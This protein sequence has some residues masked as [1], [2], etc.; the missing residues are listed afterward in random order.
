M[1]GWVDNMLD[2]QYWMHFERLE[3]VQTILSEQV[4]ML[5]PQD[6]YLW[7]DVSSGQYSYLLAVA[8][9][10]AQHAAE[11][12]L[13]ETGMDYFLVIAGGGRVWRSDQITPAGFT[14]FSQNRWAEGASATIIGGFTTDENLSP[15]RWDP[16][17]RRFID[18]PERKW[19]MGVEI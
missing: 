2:P 5:V 8:S 9:P 17:A 15:W 16:R 10:E 1:I 18:H 3:R 19:G 7:V 6:W 4:R 13:S 14:W 12:S 11:A